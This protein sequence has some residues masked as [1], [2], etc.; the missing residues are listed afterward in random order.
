MGLYIHSQT[1]LKGAGFVLFIKFKWVCIVYQIEMG[2][3]CPGMTSVTTVLE[4]C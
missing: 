4:A 2:Y 1:I 3:L